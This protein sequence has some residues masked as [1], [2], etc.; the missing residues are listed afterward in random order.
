MRHVALLI[1][2]LD[3]IGGAERQVLLLA[4][5]L[6]RRGWQISVVALSG[7]GAAAV[8]ELRAEGIAFLSLG[9]RKGLADPRG[10]VRFHRWVCRE[11]PDVLHAHLPHAAWLA[12]WSRVAARGPA[13]ID[14]L[15]SSATGGLGRRLGYRLSARLPDCVTVVS[16]AAA[17]AHLRGGMVRADKLIV[18]PN[19]VDTESYRPDA[20]VREQ[21]R[22]ELGLGDAFLWLAAGRLEAVK[23]YPTL[24]Q[25]MTGVPE[26]ARLSIAGAG[27]LEGELR[28]LA[29]RLGIEERVRFAGFVP[30]IARWMQAGDGFVLSSLWDGLPMAL[31]EAAACGVPAVASDVPGVREAVDEGET[32]FLAR[33][34]DPAALAAAMRRLMQVSPGERRAIGAN[35]RRLA[36]ESFSL[37]AVLDRWER[38]YGEAIAAHR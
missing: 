8:E 13:V 32:G 21:M 24:L 22:R 16:Q 20:A 28:A 36:V 4:R 1:P 12:R 7:S 18:L 35:A 38:L 9:M 3:R 10:W 6:R 30:D 33:S 37:D 29:A 5:G 34:G 2:G 15:H 19:G 17:D 27:P 31:L 23:D 14:T 25:A 26:P 11:R